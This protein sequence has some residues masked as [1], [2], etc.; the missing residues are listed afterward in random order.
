MEITILNI[1]ILEAVNREVKEVTN[2]VAEI[3]AP[4]KSLQQATKWLDGQEVCQLLNISKRTLQTYRVKGI[5]GATQ[6]NRKNYFK[7]TDVEFLMQSGQILKSRKNG[8]D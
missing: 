7:M 5:L 1:Q 8:T 2:L 6:V 4:Y 3:T